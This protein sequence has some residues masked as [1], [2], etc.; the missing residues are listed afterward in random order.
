MKLV[1]IDDRTR[2][3]EAAG[4]ERIALLRRM[5]GAR[6]ELKLVGGG[7]CYDAT[8]IES[9][10]KAIFALTRAIA[11]EAVRAKAEGLFR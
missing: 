10:P 8:G 4:G 6:W 2:V 5:E 1:A 11:Q 3:V 9:E 7:M